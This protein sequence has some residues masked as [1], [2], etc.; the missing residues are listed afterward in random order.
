MWKHGS[1]FSGSDRD[2]ALVDY[3]R[4]IDFFKQQFSQSREKALD[5]IQTST[6]VCQNSE[7]RQLL[8]D[9]TDVAENTIA[10]AKKLPGEHKKIY[11]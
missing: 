4:S 1:P 5:S 7:A 10:H 9:L 11:A 8:E 6:D 2:E 3:F